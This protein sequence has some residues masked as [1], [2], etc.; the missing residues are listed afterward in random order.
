MKKARVQIKIVVVVVVA[1]PSRRKDVSHIM[2]LSLSSKVL[3]TLNR[4]VFHFLNPR[5]PKQ[6]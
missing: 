6:C 1:Y 2:K 4:P 5:L 3:G